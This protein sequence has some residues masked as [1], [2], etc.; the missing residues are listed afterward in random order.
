[1]AIVAVDLVE[2]AV[3]NQ[4][5]PVLVAVEM[6]PRDAGVVRHDVRLAGERKRASGA[7]QIFAERYFADR[8]RHAVPGRAVARHVAAGVERHARGAAHAGLHERAIE[9][10]AAPRELVEMSRREKGMAVAAEM[11]GAQL[12]A[13]D[14]QD[15]ADRAHRSVTKLEM[16][17]AAARVL[18]RRHS[19]AG[20]CDAQLAHA[21]MPRHSLKPERLMI[22]PQRAVSAAMMAAS[23][24]GVVPVGS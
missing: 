4:A 19:H 7:A 8:Q 22:G 20:L 12:V 11:I 14:E 1:M 18:V 6:Q 3:A 24:S 23:A 15:V 16:R 13:H 2:A 5:H 9:A 17:L 10:H 21:S